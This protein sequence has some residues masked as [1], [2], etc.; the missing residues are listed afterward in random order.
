MGILSIYGCNYNRLKSNLR[1]SMQRLK[2]L[3]KKKTEVSLKARK[4]V[5]DYLKINKVDRARIRV[6]HIVRE[7]YLVEAM[8][9]VEMY[10]DLFIS[11]FG[12][13]SSEKECDKGLTEA[14]A[15]ILWVSPRMQADVP[16][17]KVVREQLINKYGKEF[18]DACLSNAA[19]VVNPKVMRNMNL[20]APPCNI[21]EMYLVSYFGVIFELPQ[22]KQWLLVALSP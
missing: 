11:R 13:F 1:I 18:V 12:L 15:T 2:L 9:I 5:A 22:L 4:E 14:I 3:Q 19:S 7:D 10:C 8:E 17:L 21:C 6:E 20:H 16:E